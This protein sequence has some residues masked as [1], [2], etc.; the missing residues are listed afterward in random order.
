MCIWILSHSCRP[1]SG[2]KRLQDLKWTDFPQYN[3]SS[4]GVH[5]AGDLW[6]T[7]NCKNKLYNQYVAHDNPALG[8][9]KQRVYVCS[10]WYHHLPNEPIFFYAGDEAHLDQAGPNLFTDWSFEHNQGLHVYAEVSMTKL[11]LH[12]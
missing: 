4:N 10:L 6:G 9:W 12:S 2:M 1:G 11:Q 5:A 3:L 8:T 7:P